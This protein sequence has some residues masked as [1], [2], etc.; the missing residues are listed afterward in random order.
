MRV[1]LRFMPAPYQI[2]GGGDNRVQGEGC[3]Q[4]PTLLRANRE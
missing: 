2:A 3:G 1:V 4:P